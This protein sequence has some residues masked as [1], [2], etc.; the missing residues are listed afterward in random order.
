[1]LTQPKLVK[2]ENSHNKSINLKTETQTKGSAKFLLG[3]NNRVSHMD[4]RITR[5][6]SASD[7]I[8]RHHIGYKELGLTFVLA[9][10]M[11]TSINL[12]LKEFNGTSPNQQNIAQ[13]QAQLIPLLQ[14]N[15]QLQS[16][17]KSHATQAQGDAKINHQ[18]RDR[19]KHQ[20]PFSSFYADNY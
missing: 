17:I 19:K 16:A 7:H 1:M 6:E 5:L 3:L 9:L 10:L 12:G 14:Q 13:Q 11:F 18:G 20:D 15:A 8:L 4:K 2:T